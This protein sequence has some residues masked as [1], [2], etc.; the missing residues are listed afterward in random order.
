M[1]TLLAVALI[2]VGIFGV[3]RAVIIV[4]GK[5]HGRFPLD[6]WLSLILGFALCLLGQALLK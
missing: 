2:V 1:M 6:P 5:G 4:A 3:V